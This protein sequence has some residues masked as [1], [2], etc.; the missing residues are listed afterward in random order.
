MIRSASAADKIPRRASIRAWA[1]E[2]AT[3]WGKRRQ[4][5]PTELFIST[6]EGA[7]PSANRLPRAVT[8]SLAGAPLANRARLLVELHRRLDRGRDRL[9]VEGHEAGVLGAQH[10]VVA[11]PVDAVND[12]ERIALADEHD[13]R[14][15]PR[16][17]TRVLRP[18]VD[19]H[20]L[21]VGPGGALDGVHSPRRVFLEPLA[22]LAHAR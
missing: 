11:L 7:S 15:Q 9:D 8:E 6:A 10:L 22:E 19:A 1:M 21:E 12:R 4:S 18:R 13:V 14:Q 3:S 2:P 5:N 16:G 17:A 20:Q